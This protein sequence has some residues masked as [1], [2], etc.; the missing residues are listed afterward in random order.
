MDLSVIVTGEENDPKTKEIFQLLDKL[1]K[2]VEFKIIKLGLQPDEKI[3]E[4]PQLEIGPYKLHG[5]ITEQQVLIALRAAKDRKDQIMKI[6]ES[7]TGKKKEKSSKFTVSDR[8]SLWFSDHYMIVFNAIVLLYVGVPFLAPIFMHFGWTQPANVIYKIY[9]FLCHQLAFRSFFLFGKQAVYP[10]ILSNLHYP[11]M[12]EFLVHHLTIDV[13]EAR[14][15]LGNATVG[16]KIAL[17]QRDIAMYGSFFLFG[18]IFAFFKSRIKPLKMWIWILLGIL[19]IAIDGG[20]QLPALGLD[21]KWLPA[22]ESTPLLRVIT[23]ILFGVFTAW[24]LYPMV[25]DTMKSTRMMLNKK[26]LILKQLND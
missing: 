3:A 6:E 25:E 1:K 17:C 2:H 20:S 22:R 16:Y 8:F 7:K 21:I 26:K 15:Y 11:I 19:P 23:G 14:A 5:H 18:V 9:S 13:V 4:L 12:Y 24:Y 10:R